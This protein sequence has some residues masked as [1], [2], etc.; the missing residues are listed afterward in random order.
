MYKLKVEF[1]SVNLHSKIYLACKGGDEEFYIID[2]TESKKFTSVTSTPHTIM[3]DDSFTPILKITKSEFLKLLKT[4]F[5]ELNDFNDYITKT[6]YENASTCG[7]FDYL[8][9]LAMYLSDNYVMS[10]FYTIDDVIE[11]P[12]MKK[13]I[14]TLLN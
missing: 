7:L 12:I 8:K 9:P 10:D 3:Y 6:F 4:K 14:E 5:D 13:Y 11:N 2:R 1:Q